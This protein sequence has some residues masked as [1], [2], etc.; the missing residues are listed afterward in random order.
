MQIDIQTRE[1]P[2]TEALRS[3]IERRLSFSLSGCGDRIQR[4]VVRLL[5]INGPRGGVGQHCQ[6]QVVLLGLS[7]III[8]DTETDM[9]VAIDRA[10]NR[11][12]R[13]AVRRI[14]RH[15]ALQKQGRIVFAT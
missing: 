15:K 13:T 9:R 3:H 6:L 10:C 14:K 12:G 1:L 2:L 11:A 5:D 8:E 4:V 7:D